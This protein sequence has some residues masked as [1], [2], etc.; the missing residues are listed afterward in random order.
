MLIGLSF[1]VIILLVK[2]SI[3]PNLNESPK[4]PPV[5]EATTIK[6][7]TPSIA[8]LPFEDFSPDKDLCYFTSGRSEEILN[9]LAKTNKLRVAARTSSFAFQNQTIDIRDIGKK[10][11]V[12]TILEGSIRKFNY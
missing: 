11:E 2:P 4:Q 5:S 9:L 7:E 3:V 8:I 10:L 12:N 6:D 1:A